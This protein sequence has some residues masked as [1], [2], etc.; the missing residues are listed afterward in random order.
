MI[1]VYWALEPLTW[2]RVLSERALMWEQQKK[3]TNP[4]RII[5]LRLYCS[6]IKV[7]ICSIMNCKLFQFIRFFSSL[8]LIF[9]SFFFIHFSDELWKDNEKPF[10]SIK[11]LLHKLL[12]IKY[13]IMCYFHSHH[14]KNNISA[15]HSTVLASCGCTMFFFLRSRKNRNWQATLK[16]PSKNKFYKLVLSNSQ[17]NIRV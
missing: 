16:C 3:K 2:L 11:G 1:H 15:T 6:Q 4:W 9:W 10:A 14:Y 7:T 17:T 8:I 5:C 12:C 13:I